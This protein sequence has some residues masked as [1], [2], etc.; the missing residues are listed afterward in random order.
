MGKDINLVLF[1]AFVVG[2]GLI[3][4]YEIAKTL[5]GVKDKTNYNVLFVSGFIFHIICEYGGVNQWYSL[6]YCEILG[7][8]K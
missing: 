8:K 3:I 2:V 5:F 1:E 7:I 6:K 4:V